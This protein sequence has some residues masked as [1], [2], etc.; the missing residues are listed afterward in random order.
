MTDVLTAADLAMERL[1]GTSIVCPE[2]GAADTAV[3]DTRPTSWGAC[4]VIRRRRLCVQCRIRFTTYELIAGDLE[5]LAGVDQ[6]AAVADALAE[7]DQ[8]VRKV[9]NLL[10]RR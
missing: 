10:K 9:A 7:I 3:K 5:K 4:S 6:P 1:R 2:C 8:A